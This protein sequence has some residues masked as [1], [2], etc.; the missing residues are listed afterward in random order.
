MDLNVDA[1]AGD[2][3]ITV[4]GSTFAAAD[5]VAGGDGTD[6]VTLSGAATLA[7]ADF[8]NKTTVEALTAANATNSLTLGTKASTQVSP[9]SRVVPVMTRSM[10]LPLTLHWRSTLES[11][12][13]VITTQSGTLD[14]NVD[15]GAGDDS[16][17]V[18]SSKFAAADTVAGG[19]GTDTITLS[20]AA[21]LT[22]GAFANKTTVE[23]LTAANATNSLTLG[24]ESSRCRSRDCHWR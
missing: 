5:T 22:D 4:T 7:D 1:G 16:I 12:A 8:A 13:D 9:L 3:S 21:T 11:G 10:Q 6:T 15:A 20:G 14:L 2:D 19:D 23:G 17:T 24:T 18:T